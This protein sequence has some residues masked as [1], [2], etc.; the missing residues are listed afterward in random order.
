MTAVH[1]LPEEQINSTRA[2][3][4]WEE[5]FAS[6][7]EFVGATGTLPRRRSSDLTERSL[8]EWAGK[9]LAKRRGKDPVPLADGQAELLETI[10]G[11]KWAKSDTDRWDQN[12]SA[13]REFI[14][15]SD[16]MPSSESSNS[17]EASLG[18]WVHQARQ[19]QRGTGHS[20]M[21]S[22][23]ARLLEAI[24][25]WSWYPLSDGDT[26]DD[27]VH[28]LQLH[29]AQTG[30]M[31]STGLVSAE[32]KRLARWVHHVKAARAGRGTMVITES[33]A[34]SLE[35]IDGWEW[36]TRSADKRWDENFAALRDFISEHGH[37][38]SATSVDGPTAKLGRW[39][40]TYRMVYK[41]NDNSKGSLT[42]DRIQRLEAIEHWKW[43][44]RSRRK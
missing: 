19:A 23:R 36:E 31:P 25:G 41:S 40:N 34:A 17:R 27:N 30:R 32:E 39:V 13:L 37:L 10:P 43:A 38:P 15:A 26:W 24:P 35:R 3:A 2:A 18:R 6:L 8:A 29:V 1:R 4:K 9:Q 5:R 16:R 22:E 20:V 7:Q 11:W 42:A 14:E 12:L 21:T 33:R 44:G 28:L